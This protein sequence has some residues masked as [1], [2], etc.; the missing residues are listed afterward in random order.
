MSYIVY[1]SSGTVLTTVPTGKIDTGTTSIA[2]IG[3]DVTNYGRYY[4]QNLVDILSNF[5]NSSSNPP[6]SPI[7]GQLW[8]DISSKRLKVYDTEFQ[9]IGVATIS[10]TKP[11]GQD[12]GGF[13]YDSNNSSLNFLD[14]NGHYNIIASFPGTIYDNSVG[15][16]SQKVTLLQ[17]YGEVIGALSTAS[18]TASKFVST[19]TFGLA[20]TSSFSIVSGLTIIGDIRITGKIIADGGVNSS[21]TASTFISKTELKAIV[22][23]S[24]NWG[25]FQT[26]IANL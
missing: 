6:S 9:T 25:Q 26:N 24:S 19:T 14:D 5:A 20:G 7:T 2:L 11:I 4:N 23:A 8:Y 10:S 3:R 12:P 16:V 22:A 13:W 15:G 17:N 21:S 18:F 1:T